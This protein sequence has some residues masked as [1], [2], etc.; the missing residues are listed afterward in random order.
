MGFYLR[1]PTDRAAAYARFA[2]RNAAY[3]AMRL[4]E[5]GLR[6]SRGAAEPLTSARPAIST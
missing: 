5:G 1:V 2:T 3:P 6:L 4:N